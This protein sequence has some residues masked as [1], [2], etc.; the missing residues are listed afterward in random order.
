M[1]VA[2]NSLERGCYSYYSPV[3]QMHLRGFVGSNASDATATATTTLVTRAASM[4]L[5][6]H[7]HLQPHAEQQ[8]IRPPDRPTHPDSY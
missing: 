5:L 3:Q 1:P 4:L 8:P 7:I 6:S 2:S